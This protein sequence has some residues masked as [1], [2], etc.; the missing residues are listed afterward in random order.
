MRT[1]EVVSTE[2]DKTV[3]TY[4]DAGC[5]VRTTD[6]DASGNIVCD[7]HYDID[8]LQHIVGW[9]VLDANA[10]IL[11]RFE[12]DYDSK[13]LEIEHRQYGN[14]DKLER[15]EKYLYD[16][17]NQRVEEQHYDAAGT[18][19]SRKI[20]TSTG[21]GTNAQYYDAMGNPIAGPAA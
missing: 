13:G 3:Y 2:G 12:V 21:E 1:E 5:T 17:N 4:N 18:L 6:Y 11:K 16:D 14:D 7:I 8:G 9:K 10:N 20:Y 15:Q 19:R